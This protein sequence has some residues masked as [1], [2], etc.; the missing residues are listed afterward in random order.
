[1]KKGYSILIRRLNPDLELTPEL[2]LMFANY[3]GVICSGGFDKQL[4][5]CRVS[6]PSK[7]NRA[8]VANVLVSNGIR[9]G[10]P[11]FKFELGGAHE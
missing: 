5:F 10:F 3:K 2:L 8:A 6:F 1:M 9:F 7:K 11:D 4:Y